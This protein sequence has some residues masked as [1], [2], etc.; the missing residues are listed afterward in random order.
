MSLGRT[1]F[2]S[3]KSTRIRRKSGT[4]PIVCGGTF[5][6]ICREAKKNLGYDELAHDA[7]AAY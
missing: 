4:F 1:V 3:S 6:I 5:P 2:K 7:N